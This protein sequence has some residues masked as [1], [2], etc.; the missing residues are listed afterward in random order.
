MGRMSF[1]QE[2]RRHSASSQQAGAGECFS[3]RS[4][5]LG[6]PMLLQSVQSVQKGSV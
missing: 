2:L 6:L 4:Y 3:E 1:S 5:R